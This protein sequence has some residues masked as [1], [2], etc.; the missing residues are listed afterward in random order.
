[1]AQKK[2]NRG[3]RREGVF[4]AL[5]RIRRPL[6]ILS[7]ALALVALGPLGPRDAIAGFSAT[8]PLVENNGNYSCPT[9]TMNAAALTSNGVVIGQGSQATKVAALNATATKKYLQ[10]TSSGEPTFDQPTLLE[11][12]NFTGANLATRLNGDSTGGTSKVVY[13]TNPSIAGLTGTGTWNL[14]GITAPLSLPNDALDDINDFKATIKSGGANAVKLATIGAGST[15]AGKQLQLDAQGN[16]EASS[17]NTGAAGSIVPH[18]TFSPLTSITVATG[19]PVFCNLQGVCS[20]TANGTD[21]QTKMHDTG[22]ITKLYCTPQV[23]SGIA[24]T[25]TGRTGTCGNALA[26]GDLTA[27]MGTTAWAAPTS[28]SGSMT[29]ADGDCAVI[30]FT[31]ASSTTGKIT[32]SCTASQTAGT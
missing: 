26:T 30:I 2:R 6:S 9:C 19:T 20:T 12:Q 1:M 7:L 18:I 14:S 15:A 22:T 28:V 27:T 23:A 13:D 29:W 11:L 8:L 16:I 25:V 24:V 32:V 17:Y 10:Q 5:R 21:V 31:A 4:I 3:G